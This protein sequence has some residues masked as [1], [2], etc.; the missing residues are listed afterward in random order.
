MILICILKKKLFEKKIE[1]ED[2]SST[3]C[4]ETINKQIPKCNSHIFLHLL[5]HVNYNTSN[6]FQIHYY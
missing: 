5:S 6:V 3:V 2:K 4:I 1:F